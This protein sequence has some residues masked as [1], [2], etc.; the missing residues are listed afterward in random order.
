MKKYR[1]W[2]CIYCNKVTA[3]TNYEY[4][5]L[6]YIKDAPFIC[7]CE[8]VRTH[9]FENSYLKMHT[10]EEIELMITKTDFTIIGL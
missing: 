7:Q 6:Y 4:I 2:K 5:D 1:V 3:I 9:Y 8:N 10:K